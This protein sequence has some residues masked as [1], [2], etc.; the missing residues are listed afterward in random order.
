MVTRVK[1]FNGN[2]RGVGDIPRVVG[3]VCSAEEYL[4]LEPAIPADVIEIRLDQMPGQ[5]DWLE[6]GKAIEARGVPVILTIRLQ[7]EGGK[8]S[9]ADR[10][11]LPLF[12]QA[13][14]HLS[15]VDIEL[16]SG[17]AATVAQEAKRLGKICIVSFHDFEQTP[18]LPKLKSVVKQASELGSIAKISTMART[19]ADIDTLQ[20]LLESRPTTPLCVIAM[21]ALG[22]QT[23]VSFPTLGSCLTY[24]Y[25]GR[26]AAPGQLPAAELVRQLRA[27]L[28]RYNEHWMR[29]TA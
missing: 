7:A 11:R 6:R 15:A 28:P 22:T 27:L 26:P 10:D 25:I 13:L 14:K 20:Q 19:Q 9:Q 29:R 12:T 21:S 5:A 16:Q 17:L 1:W 4:A 2:G 24:G 18:G 23:R 8:W 3:T